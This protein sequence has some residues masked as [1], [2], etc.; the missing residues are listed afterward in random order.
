MTMLDLYGNPLQN[1][2]I[3]KDKIILLDLNYTLIS[4]SR[5]NTGSMTRR[6]PREEY[7]TELL[8]MIKDNT[9]IL[10]TA[11]PEKYKEDSLKNIQKKTGFIPD[12]SYWNTGMSPPQIKEYW[13]KN[14]IFPEYGED[15]KQYYA[16]E[17]NPA[18]RRMYAK[19]R[20]KSDRKE[21]IMAK[22]K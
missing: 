16:I 22:Y 7:E 5:T 8:E 18:T 3:D 15:P 4:N 6:I 12:D 13:L 19:Y 21:D 1:D 14:A 9:V 17:S 20:I 2:E 11:R 10:I